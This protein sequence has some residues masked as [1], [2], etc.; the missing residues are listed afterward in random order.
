MT[1]IFTLLA[2]V[3]LA[4]EPIWHRVTS[5][6]HDDLVNWLRTK[7]PPILVI[8]IIA[9][10]LARL[11][12]LITGKLHQYSTRDELPSRIRA[13]QLRTLAAVIHS[14]GIFVIYFFALLQILTKL[15][16]DVKPFLAS[17]GIVGLAIGFGAQTLV[18]DV[19]NGF[20]I[21]IENIYDLGDV[22]KIAGVQ[23]TVEQMS[24]RKTV[25]RDDTGALHSVPNSEV[26][27]ISNM[28]RDWAQVALHVSVDYSE[29]SDQIIQLLKQVGQDLKN[30]PDFSNAIVSDP[31][32]PG[33]ER[34]NGSEVD[35][36]L[37]VKVRPGRQYDV[38]RE[39]RKRIKTSFEQNKIK[40]GSPN[41]MYVMEAPPPAVQ[42]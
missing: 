12:G 26:K 24:L 37:V 10:I 8:L 36:L 32:V 28:T 39:L 38:R 5:G 4:D 33:I 15:D 23:G 11:L 40:A 20:F 21:I 27:I 41:R 3:W 42:S 30:D 17:A 29:S 19:I 34:V 6:W 14:V 16:I 7:L 13:Q 18:H 22:V 2:A 9:A 25:L 31:Q 35:Y 1:R